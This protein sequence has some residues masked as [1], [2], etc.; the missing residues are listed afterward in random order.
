MADDV[1]VAPWTDAEVRSLND[2][3]AAGVMHPFTCESDDEPPCN[4][5]LRAT[6]GGWECPDCDYRQNWACTF[7]TDGSWR[8]AF[9]IPV[10]ADA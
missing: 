9:G 2:Y 6:T 8:A 7:M 10:V 5:V 1:S 3:Q 4:T